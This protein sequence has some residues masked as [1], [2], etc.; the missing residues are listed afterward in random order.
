MSSYVKG[1]KE[2]SQYMQAKVASGEH[3]LS[4]KFDS[5]D[6]ELGGSYLHRLWTLD[7]NENPILWRKVSEEDWQLWI[8]PSKKG[9]KRCNSYKVMKK[10]NKTISSNKKGRNISTRAVSTSVMYNDGVGISCFVYLF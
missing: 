8:L 5:I 7:P 3:N 9:Q 2:N 4:N 1:S 10:L 6:D